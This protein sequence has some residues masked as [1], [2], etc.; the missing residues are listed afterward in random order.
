MGH[1]VQGTLAR[2]LA[3]SSPSPAT[4][5]EA[6]VEAVGAFGWGASEAA[7]SIRGCG[8]A[9]TAAL[10][11]ASSGSREPKGA[12]QKDLEISQPGQGTGQR[13]SVLEMGVCVC[14]GE[15][16]CA[17]AKTRKPRPQRLMGSL[18]LPLS[19]F[20]SP[21]LVQDPRISSPLVSQEALW[22]GRV[23]CL[24]WLRCGSCCQ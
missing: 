20:L 10:R 6:L 23:C 15:G 9:M 5:G 11:K 16:L 8:T 18:Q 4:L 24:Q 19:C 14:G 13:E 12:E 2:S 3:G 17:N 22:A 1:W 7:E 21:P